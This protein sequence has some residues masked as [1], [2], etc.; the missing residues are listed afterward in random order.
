MVFF[1]IVNICK[2]RPIE[3]ACSAVSILDIMVLE[4]RLRR[5]SLVCRSVPLDQCNSILD[6]SSF[7][8]VWV[9]LSPTPTC[10]G[11][12]AHVLGLSSPLQLQG[13]R[14][15]LTGRQGCPRSLLFPCSTPVLDTFCYT[16]VSRRRV[17]LPSYTCAALS[18]FNRTLRLFSGNGGSV[19]EI[20]RIFS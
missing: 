10:A 12:P 14:L 20:P 9:N 3:G 18:A 15:W 8:T 7:L 13:L 5:V 4:S 1:A 16:L 19:R 6:I 11:C 17:W 2:A